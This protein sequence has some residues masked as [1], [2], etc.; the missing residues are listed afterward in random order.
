MFSSLFIL[1]AVLLFA[2]SAQSQNQSSVAVA[3]RRDPHPAWEG[4]AAGKPEP[5]ARN[6]DDLRIAVLTQPVPEVWLEFAESKRE[7]RQSSRLPT[8]EKESV[9]QVLLPDKAKEI[10]KSLWEQSLEF[11]YKEMFD[12]PKTAQEAMDRDGEWIRYVTTT[13]QNLEKIEIAAPDGARKISD[14][15]ATRLVVFVRKASGNLIKSVKQ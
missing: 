10:L 15:E 13:A 5:F 7:G 1:I 8:D 9:I 4:T 2:S 12:K 6:Y 11:D 14:E 3:A